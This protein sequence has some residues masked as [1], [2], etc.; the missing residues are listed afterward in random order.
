[1]S[2]CCVSPRAFC[3]DTTALLWWRRRCEWV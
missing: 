2:A 1:L 3:R